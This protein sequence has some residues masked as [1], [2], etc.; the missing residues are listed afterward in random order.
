LEK[1]VWRPSGHEKQALLA[2]RKSEAGNQ[3]IEVFGNPCSALEDLAFPNRSS[4]E[5][6]AVRRR[7]CIEHAF[8]KQ[9]G[10]V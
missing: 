6:E 10:F 7:G 1:T 8:G 4:R 3:T 5:S 2:G 9:G